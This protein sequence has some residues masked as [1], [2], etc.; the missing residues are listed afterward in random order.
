[1]LHYHPQHV[2]LF[3]MRGYPMKWL[4][5]LGG[6]LLAALLAVGIAAY[7]LYWWADQ[8]VKNNGERNVSLE[9]APATT[10]DAVAQQLANAGVRVN[11]ELLGLWFRVSGAANR[12]KAGSYEFPPDQTPREIT[13][14]LTRGEQAQESVTFVEGWTFAQMRQALARQTHLKPNTASMSDAQVMAAL[15][16]ASQ[17][18]E[19]RFFPDTYRFAKGSSDMAVLRLAM[20][21]MDKKLAA[22]WAQRAPNTPLK[23]PEQALILASIIEKETGAKADRGKVGGVFNNRL[24]IGMRLQTD[25]TVIYGLGANFDG[26]L[27]KVDLTTDTPYNTYTRGGLTPTPISMPG[28]ASL[29]AAVKPEATKALYFVARGDGSSEFSETLAAH[30]RA[31]NRFQRGK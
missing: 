5:W 28:E 31:V 1:V 24:R 12:I 14:R 21:A 3:A 29:M 27:R 13:A 17:H 19:G 9:V 10:P 30:N 15:G 6:L 23:S 25:P 26:N 11:P 16:R 4:K 7:G 22:A 2:S 20:S 8:P 18:P